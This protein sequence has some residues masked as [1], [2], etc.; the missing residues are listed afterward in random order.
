MIDG[1]RRTLDL[2]HFYLSH[3]PGEPTGPVLDALGRAA[4]R[5][6]RVRLIL[7]AGMHSTYP[8]PADSLAGVP[9]IAVRVIDM[10]KVAGSGVQHSKYLIV[11]GEQIFV[12]SQNLDWRSLKHIHELGVRARD[13]RIA[14][15]FVRVFEMDWQASTPAGVATTPDSAV[16]AGA[17]GA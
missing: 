14:E 3:W 17:R 5:G 11:D 2:E 16:S 1:A 15:H 10:K 6:V 13:A 9:G 12:G 7:D 8:L 4:R